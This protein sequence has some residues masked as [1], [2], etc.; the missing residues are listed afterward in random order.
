MADQKQE[1]VDFAYAIDCTGSMSSYIQQVKS[2]IDSVVS[3]MSAQFPQF[4]LRLACVGYRDWCDNGDRLTQ[5]N[6][7]ENVNSF[8]NYVGNLKASGGGDQ[9]EDVLGG[10]N[11]AA[12][13]SWSSKLR[14]LF[15]IC[16]A[17][18]HNKMYHD[19]SS[20]DH[21]SGHSS[22]PANYHKVVL[23]KFKAKNIHLCI[24]KLNSSVEKMIRVFTEYG[25]SIELTVEER[26]V[27]NASQLLDAVKQTLMILTK[28]RKEIKETQA[29]VTAL[30]STLSL[31]QTSS[32]EFVEE[33]MAK[34]ET[35]DTDIK[36]INNKM[37]EVE[38]SMTEAQREYEE[39]KS[40]HSVLIAYARNARSE[41]DIEQAESDVIEL[42]TNLTKVNEKYSKAQT[43][44]NKQLEELAKKNS[45]ISTTS[46]TLTDRK[47]KITGVKTEVLNLRS[48]LDRM[49]VSEEREQMKKDIRSR[50]T[51]IRTLFS[52]N[53][54]VQKKIMNIRRD[55]LKAFKEA[56]NR[57]RVIDDCRRDVASRLNDLDT[58]LT[59][60]EDRE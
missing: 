15:H 3:E 45:A 22:D 28:V 7:S 39:L 21:P 59:E 55:V 16:D 19:I 1:T 31:L 51:E 11:C 14:V 44:I 50:L 5:Q 42:S 18:P 6:F 24:A 38:Q 56:K 35:M 52:D 23:D 8:K 20:D 47:E 58:L 12:G 13:L 29:K 49:D 34:M 27:S 10:L 41:E 33:A 9:A 37:T 36:N 17:P 53:A 26:S 40:T 4:K 32:A 2:D 54:E 57:K 43:E 46:S 60:L 48:T 25:K 30:E